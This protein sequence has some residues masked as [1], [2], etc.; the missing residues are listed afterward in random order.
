MED[1]V[2]TYLRKARLRLRENCCMV[3]LYRAPRP[4][5]SG[6]G[7][8][9]LLIHLDRRQVTVHSPWLPSVLHPGVLTC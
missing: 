6:R 8:G 7:E 5:L 3:R 2:K 9:G 1:E 4:A